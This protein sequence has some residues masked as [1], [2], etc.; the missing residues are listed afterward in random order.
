MPSKSAFE[1]RTYLD[2]WHIITQGRNT[3]NIFNYIFFLKILIL[4]KSYEISNYV[5][6]NIISS[7][8]IFK[9]EFVIKTYFS[10]ILEC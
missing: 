8:H 10:I 5:T 2:L 3:R 4:I 1:F 6:N 7:R 9:V